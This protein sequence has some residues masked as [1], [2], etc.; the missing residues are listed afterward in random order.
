MRRQLAPAA[1]P[2]S[3]G[4]AEPSIQA[5][6]DIMKHRLILFGGEERDGTSLCAPMLQ[7]VMDLFDGGLDYTDP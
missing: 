6:V 4:Q 1:I 2:K 5:D 7:V 3:R